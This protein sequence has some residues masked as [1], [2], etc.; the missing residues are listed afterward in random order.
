MLF[1]WRQGKFWSGSFLVPGNSSLYVFTCSKKILLQEQQHQ[2]NK[3]IFQTGEK[4]L[5]YAKTINFPFS[6]FS[7]RFS[8]GK[9]VYRKV[10]LSSRISVKN[11]LFSVTL[12]TA[13]NLR[14]PGI[15]NEENARSFP[16][17]Q[18]IQKKENKILSFLLKFHVL[19]FNW[20]MGKFF[21]LL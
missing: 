4:V 21:F 17:D 13:I 15:P 3:E 20:V 5:L 6:P 2:K 19:K 7:V 10:I 16:K 14:L 12:L 9:K 8:L 18:A 1:K 11:P